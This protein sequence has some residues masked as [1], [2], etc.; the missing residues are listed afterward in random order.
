MRDGPVYTNLL[1]SSL[2]TSGSYVIK[3]L[4]QLANFVPKKEKSDLLLARY[5]NSI[6]CI[7]PIFDLA[8]FHPLYE[9]FWN[10]YDSQVNSRNSTDSSPLPIPSSLDLDFF[11]VLFTILY[12]G[13]VSEFEEFTISG[14]MLGDTNS[15]LSQVS[16]DDRKHE[17]ASQLKYF[18]GAAEIAL[19][20]SDFPRTVSIIGLQSSVILHSVLRNDCRTDDC[21]SVATLVRCAQL[22]ELHRD[23]LKYH[24]FT[25]SS[26]I[27]G[28]RM[29]WWQIVHLDL[30]SAL[31][32]RLC[33]MINMDQCDTLLPS[34]YTK[35]HDGTYRLDPTVTFAN[36]KFRW[37]ECCNKIMHASSNLKLTCDAEGTSCL[38][39]KLN[40]DIS[41]LNFY[42]SS[43]IQRIL[44][45]MN[46]LPTKEHFA[47][48]SSSVLSTLS[49]RCYTLLHLAFTE[50][51]K[52]SSNGS[53]AGSLLNSRVGS[54]ESSQFS[55]KD[56]S[57]I[58]NV[59][60]EKVD[61]HLIERQIHL[62]NEF[63][64]YGAMPH[65]AVFLWEIR[66]FQP[67]QA[68]LSLLRS[69]IL[70]VKKWDLLKHDDFSRYNK[71]LKNDRKV[72]TICLAIDKLGYLSEHATQLC[73]ER[74]KLIRDLKDATWT[75]LFGAN[76]NPS[77]FVENADW[78]TATQQHKYLL[79]SRT[80]PLE[81]QFQQHSTVSESL[82]GDSGSTSPG[83][84][85][86]NTD[87]MLSVNT[88]SSYSEEDV[89]KLTE[90][91]WNMILNELDS[92]QRI[93]DENINAKLWDHSG[94]HFL[95]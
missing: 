83:D 79:L 12:A 58:A 84:S 72:L 89:G 18:V 25:D 87:F 61:E 44:D 88:G 59:N 78:R 55:N 7:I 11:I 45:P 81:S 76:Y 37:V 14:D 57:S 3:D 30:T 22:I 42:C 29:L 27:Q 65:N 77:S 5:T 40:K 2:N 9:L 46:I 53:Q 50:V 20:M 93:I 10:S 75:Q 80:Q 49:D 26:V 73:R 47:N 85:G 70:E 33:P 51:Y 43:S 32:S 82:T 67:I 91:E 60:I 38:V 19:A 71:L 90:T 63:V 21:G 62:L 41:E 8:S 39:E 56:L 24:G 66:K 68:I 94:G 36:G 86:S 95:M 15:S 74:W 6:H 52:K 23:P 1:N 92:V 64:K 54:I 69:L 4:D 31:S 16:F 28:R 17:Y 35:A 48:F 13:S 34:E